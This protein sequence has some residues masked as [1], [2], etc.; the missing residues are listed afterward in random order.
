MRRILAGLIAWKRAWEWMAD[1]INWYNATHR[2]SGIG[3]VTP[4]QRKNGEDVKLFEKRNQT[5]KEVRLLLC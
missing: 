5:L 1:F 2:H 3:Y 4:Q